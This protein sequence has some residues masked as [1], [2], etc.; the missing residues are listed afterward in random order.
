MFGIVWIMIILF[1]ALLV[2]AMIRATAY[3]FLTVD[4][5]TLSVFKLMIKHRGLDPSKIPDAALIDIVVAKIGE[6][7]TKALAADATSG[8]TADWQRYLFR[9][10]DEDADI[11]EKVIRNGSEKHGGSATARTLLKYG[12][13]EPEY[14]PLLSVE[15]F[16][17]AANRGTLFAELDDRIAKRELS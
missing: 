13:V 3:R 15:E 2:W 9:L 16:M 10:L 4:E 11:I 8:A 6:A 1:V 12:V 14:P 5:T 17:D 7:K